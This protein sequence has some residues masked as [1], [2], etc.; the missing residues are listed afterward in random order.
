MET[1]ETERKNMGKMA[2]V[3]E[4]SRGYRMHRSLGAGMFIIYIYNSC[5]YCSWIAINSNNPGEHV[6]T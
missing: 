3:I 1:K 2:I 4:P 5:V 6:Y